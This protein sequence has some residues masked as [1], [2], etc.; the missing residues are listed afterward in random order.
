MTTPA[1]TIQ[2]GKG[3]GRKPWQ[4]REWLAGQGLNMAAVA[5]IAQVH[6][7]V[8]QETVRGTRNHN[9]VLAVLEELGCPSQYLYGEAA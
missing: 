4:V 2:R 6:H 3:K 7:N 9:R 1:I 8:V 5:R